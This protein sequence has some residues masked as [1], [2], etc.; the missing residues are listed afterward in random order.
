MN[1]M[2]RRYDGEDIVDSFEVNSSLKRMDMLIIMATCI[3]LIV[4]GE[5]F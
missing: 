1:E 4:I 2:Y 3:Q 5:D